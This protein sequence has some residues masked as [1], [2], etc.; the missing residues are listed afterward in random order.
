[1]FKKI[2]TLTLLTTTLFL[3]GCGSASQSSSKSIETTIDDF[4][5]S[6]DDTGNLSLLKYTGKNSTLKIESSYDIEGTNYPVTNLNNFQIGIGNRSVKTVIISEGITELNYSIF[7]SCKVNKIYLPKSLSV[8]YDD[9]LAYLNKDKI[10]IYYGGTED[11]WNTIF[12]EY[13]GTDDE[14]AGKK[15]AEKFNSALGFEYDS[16]KFTFHYE[17]T[18]DNLY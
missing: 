13:T 11:E 2:L 18:I 3:S 10:D 15:L 12:T 4:T 5:Y 17:S 8:I 14:N 7:N 1:M 6:I 16:S 9:T